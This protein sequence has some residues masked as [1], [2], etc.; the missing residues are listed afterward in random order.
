MGTRPKERFKWNLHAGG[1]NTKGPGGFATE[2]WR[3][4][5][6]AEQIHMRVSSPLKYPGPSTVMCYTHSVDSLSGLTLV[7]Q[8]LPSPSVNVKGKAI[9]SLHSPFTPEGSAR[10]LTQNNNEQLKWRSFQHIALLWRGIPPKPQFS[11][12]SCGSSL[13]LSSHMALLTA[14]K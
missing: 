8:P 5:K 10:W 14:S 11:L 6:T 13:L 7:L 3:M 12:D 9:L 2:P 4:I 1:H